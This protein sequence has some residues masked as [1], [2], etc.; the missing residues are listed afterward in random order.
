L[1]IDSV[2]GIE[3]GWWEFGVNCAFFLIY[4][5]LA[6]HGIQSLTHQMPGRDALLEM[7]QRFTRYYKKLILAMLAVWSI[8]IFCD[9]V[10]VLIHHPL[11]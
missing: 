4:I 1:H 10:Y 11:R 2:C 3:Y 5:V 8:V 7:K 6:I 9:L